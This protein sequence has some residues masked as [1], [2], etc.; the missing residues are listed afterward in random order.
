MP[1]NKQS[2]KSLDIS[3]ITASSEFDIGTKN[4][5]TQETDAGK[6]DFRV[7]LLS[8]WTKICRLDKEKIFIEPV[9]EEIAPDYFMIIKQP[10]DLTKVK[11]KIDRDEYENHHDFEDNQGFEDRIP[12]IISA[13]FRQRQ[14]KKT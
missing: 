14:T 6:H 5:K 13:R 12:V 4:N 8:L 2:S 1:R 7:I 3:S 11:S 10:M 9:T